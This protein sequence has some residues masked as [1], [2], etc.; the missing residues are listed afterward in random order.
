MQVD[1]GCVGG[2][3]KKTVVF[4]SCCIHIVCN[5]QIRSD[6]IRSD[7]IRSD[8]IRSDQIRSDQIRSDDTEDGFYELV[9]SVCN[10]TVQ[11]LHYSS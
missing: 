8:Q 3:E 1:D 4:L 7:Q 5:N 6:Q 11:M 9:D 2:A 10:A